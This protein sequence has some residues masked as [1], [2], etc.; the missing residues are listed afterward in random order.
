[1]TF[2]E[3]ALIIVVLALVIALVIAGILW[4]SNRGDPE[5]RTIRT[6]RQENEH[7][8]NQAAVRASEQIGS[9][10][11]LRRQ[12]R[13][14]RRQLVAEEKGEG[15]EARIDSLYRGDTGGGDFNVEA[16]PPP[17]DH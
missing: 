9:S 1:M 11:A 13:H 7:S 4:F 8:A 6:E 3:G 2:L 10:N 17:P 5:I 12:S 15:H 14:L 16:P